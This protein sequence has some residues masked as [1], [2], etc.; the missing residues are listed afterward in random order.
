[1]QRRH[2]LQAGAAT[3]LSAS[4]VR[5]ANERVKLALIG[6]GGRGRYVSGFMKELDNVDLVA[7]CDVYLPNAESARQWAGG[8]AAAYQDFRRALDRK[9]IDAVVVATPDHWHAA[10]TILAAR[11]GKDV[12]VE[13]PLTHNIDEGK[14]MVRAARE[15]KRLI[16]AGLQHRSAPHF[17]ELT[18]LVRKGELGEI[19]YVRV[20]N[21]INFTPLGIGKEPD[22]AAPP[23]LDWDMFCGPAPL[24]PYNCKRFMATFRWFFDYSGGYITDFGTHR[25]DTVHQIMGVDA[26]RTVNAT[27][28]R[29]S[30]DDA[31]EIP[32]V[33]QVT[34]E[35]P[36]F[37]LSYEGIMMN[38][39]GIPATPNMRRYY[40]SRGL[41]DRPNGIA[42]F[43]TRG[44]I[45]A[46]RIGYEIYPEL[47]DGGMWP[48]GA[49]GAGR[50]R[51]Q[52]RKVQGADATRLHA[53]SFIHNVRAGKLPPGVDVRTGHRSTIAPHLGNIS[54]KTGLKLRWDGEKE[55][56]IDAPGEARALLSRP[57][58]KPWNLI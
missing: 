21:T 52:H 48:L 46:D 10:A 7:A 6:C 57:Y 36:G 35:Y 19:R 51:T 54:F 43:G 24:A 37:V 44:A 16:Q 5:G 25:F 56:F 17:A 23:G 34:Y 30:V 18:E 53:Q 32:D 31:G 22:C 40:N 14:A 41:F 49:P 45:Y 26:P 27:G 29:F 38:G 3:A 12:Y 39:F 47:D 15:T 42:F 1:M 13:K 58:R 20:W 2:F 50:F 33:L 8:N 11:A 28:G 9:D 4:R 55:E